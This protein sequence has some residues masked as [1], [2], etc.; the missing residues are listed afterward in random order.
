MT[1][2]LYTPVVSF[3]VSMLTFAKLHIFPATP[4]ICGYL[5]TV[6]LCCFGLNFKPL[7]VGAAWVISISRF[8]LDREIRIHVF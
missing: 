3:R 1:L 8:V 7:S 6:F 5:V 4:T 2:S